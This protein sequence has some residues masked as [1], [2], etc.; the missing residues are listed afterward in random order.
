MKIFNICTQL[1]L[2]ACS[3]V[4]DGDEQKVERERESARVSAS[5]R[6]LNES[7]CKM[8]HLTA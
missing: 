7:F 4:V 8:R 6:K 2:R 5:K 3:L 1:R